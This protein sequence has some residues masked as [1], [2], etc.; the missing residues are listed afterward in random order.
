MRQ[1]KIEDS[2]DAGLEL[3]IDLW[4]AGAR[5][6]ALAMEIDR[7]QFEEGIRNKLLDQ[8]SAVVLFEGKDEQAVPLAI[9]MAAWLSETGR[10]RMAG[11][12]ARWALAEASLQKEG[13]KWLLNQIAR[14]ARLSDDQKLLRRVEVRLEKIREEEMAEE[15]T[16]AAG[17]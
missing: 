10:F 7:W 6:P 3:G 13:T 2:K 4:K 9:E 12:V 17:P 16:G 8:S 14:I 5:G 1:A 15:A 11:E